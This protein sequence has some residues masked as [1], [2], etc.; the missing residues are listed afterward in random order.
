MTATAESCSGGSPAGRPA[1]S[2]KIGTWLWPGRIGAP[3][4]IRTR[5]PLLRR[6]PL[7]PAEL[8]A[9]AP[10]VPVLG[11]AADT[12][13]TAGQGSPRQA[14]TLYQYRSWALY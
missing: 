1:L 14:G 9:P 7:C 12:E 6:Q 10:I 2:F 13:R 5:V 11:H 3:G 8:Q 4:R